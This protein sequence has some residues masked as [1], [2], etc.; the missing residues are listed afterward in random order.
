MIRQII[1]MYFLLDA[2]LYI[3]SVLI[4]GGIYLVSGYLYDRYTWL[5]IAD[6]SLIGENA[7]N[8]VI[9]NRY[10]VRCLWKRACQRPMKD[11]RI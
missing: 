2:I 8:I 4:P 5:N 3:Y 1:L 10:V 11:G 6:H 9:Y 7:P